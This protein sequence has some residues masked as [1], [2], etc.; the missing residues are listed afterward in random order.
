MTGLDLSDLVVQQASQGILPVGEE[1]L[2]ADAAEGRAPLAV[3]VG[4]EQCASLHFAFSLQDSNLPLLPAFPQLLR[5]AFV[6]AHG[7]AAVVAAA[8]TAPVPEELDLLTV[9]RGPDRVLPPFAGE[10]RDLAGWFVLGGL[11]CLALRAFVR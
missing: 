11:L 5:R 3:L 8:T 2:W 1:L 6:R 4:T 7:P 10:D 9:A